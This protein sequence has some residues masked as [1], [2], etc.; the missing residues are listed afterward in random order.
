MRTRTRTTGPDGKDEKDVDATLLCKSKHTDTEKPAHSHVFVL[1]W[2]RNIRAWFVLWHHKCLFHCK[3][4]HL[5]PFGVLRLQFAPGA[6]FP[7]FSYNIYPITPP[8]R[9]PI[10]VTLDC[11][12][13][14]HAGNRITLLYAQFESVYWS[15]CAEQSEVGN[16]QVS[17]L[18]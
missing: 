8:T 2:V 17:A 15:W 9:A 12:K 18:W 4:A 10:K 7:T 16:G 6:S 1:R 3:V 11:F 13:A 5:F 14:A